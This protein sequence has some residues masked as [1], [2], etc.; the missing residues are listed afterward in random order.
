MHF[1]TRRIVRFFVLCFVV[2]SGA[3]AQSRAAA[4]YTLLHAFAG[5]PNDGTGPLYNSSV[6]SDGT[7]LYGVTPNGGITNRGVLFKIN[8]NG[9]GYQVLHFFNGLSFTDMLLGGKGNT[10]DGVSPD[11]TPLLI[12]ATLYGTTTQGGTNGLGTVYKINTDGSGF[13]LLH[14]FGLNTLVGD[15]SLPQCSLVTDGTNLFGMTTS[16]TGTANDLGTIFRMDTNGDNYFVFHNFG[17]QPNNGNSPQGSLMYSGGTLYGMT[18]MGGTLSSGT[19]FKVGTDGLGFQIIHS[20]IGTL[21]DG[22][23]PYGSVILSGSTLYGMTSAG[24]S[25]G[26]GTVFSVDTGGTGFTILHNFSTTDTWGPLGDLTLS[27]STLFGMSRNSGFSLLGSGTIFQINTD[28]SSFQIPHVFSFPSNVKDGSTPYGSLVLL[29]STFYGMTHF[30]GSTTNAGAL[31]SF[32]TGGGG[33]GG[34]PVTALRVTIQPTTA[35]KAGAQWQVNGGVFLNSGALASGLTAGAHVVSYKTIPGFI[36]PAPQIIDITAGITNTITGIYGVA[37]T[38]PP[39]LKVISPTS[40]TSVN[41]NLFTATGTASDNVGLALVYYQLNS[42]A[43]TAASSGNSFANWTAANLSLIPGVNV[44]KFYAKDLSGNVS[45]TNTV[46][47]GYNVSVP[48]GIDFN[49][50]G[51]GTIKGAVNGQLLQIG[52]PFSLS[53]KAAKGY[54]FLNWTGG[55]NTTS[56]KITFIMVSNLTFTANFRDTTRPVN[57]ILSPTKGQT[58]SNAAPI[59][60]GRAMD[61]TG[62]TAVWCRVNTGAWFQANL[63]DGTNWQTASL[64]TQLADGPNTVSAYALDAAGNASLTNTIAFTFMVPPIADWAPDSLNRLLALVSPSINSQEAVGFD[65]STFAQTST[66]HDGNA[67]DYGGGTYTYLK[68]DTN[69]AQLSLAF[70]APPG[71][72]NNQGPI[73]LVFTNHYAGYFTNGGGDSGGINFQSATAFIPATVTGKTLNVVSNHNGKKE[74]V[75]WASATAFTKTPSNNSSSGTSSGNYTFTRFSPVCGVVALSFTSAADAGQTAYLQL[76]FS[77]ASAG[78][79]FVMI[80]DGGGTLLDIDTGTFTM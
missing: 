46:S 42:G 41:S 1:A 67:D 30:G 39:T 3:L 21:T 11:G 63:T 72:A 5:G 50:P 73:N 23:S 29:G 78:T 66:S 79:Y 75:K 34:G 28:G 10:N 65:Q 53:V 2:W 61:N 51:A 52:K 49:P 31:F 4:Q 59:A 58:V 48:V 57:V 16:G 47:F 45:A 80:F 64:A 74:K 33:G 68:T 24:G 8:V 32:G 76:T 7:F 36:S 71:A 6:S 25:N 26:V 12:G 54:S 60:T 56:A 9:S 20:F 70:T 40:K 55:T 77:S 35:V 37:D 19:I 62:V 18:L 38:T 44:I 43:W 27:G 69:L 15:G 13:Q 14:S 17:V 22:A